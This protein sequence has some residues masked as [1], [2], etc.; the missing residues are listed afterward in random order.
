QARAA[1]SRWVQE[2]GLS[3]DDE[4][5]FDREPEHILLA[6][7]L[8]ALGRHAEATV[9]LERLLLAAEAGGRTER[10]IEILVLRALAFQALGDATQALAC[11]ERAL[12]MAEPEGYMRFFLDEGQAMAE[13]MR[14]AVSR[15]IAPEYARTLLSA[16]VTPTRETPTQSLVEPL[17]E[18]ESQVLQLLTTDLSGP[19]IAEKLMVSVNTVRFHT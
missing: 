8:I 16:F 17:S 7:A 15:D 2:S 10:A 11:V 9:L 12:S 5:A 1:A 3:A 18:R 19:E 4:L 13:L 6:R 14:Q